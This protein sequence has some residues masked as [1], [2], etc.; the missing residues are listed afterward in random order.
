MAYF[1]LTP[2]TQIVVTPNKSQYE[3]GETATLRIEYTVDGKELV[4]GG[5]W[6]CYA[7]VYVD[8]KKYTT[9]GDQK[10]NEWG[11]TETEVAVLLFSFKVQKAGTITVEVVPK[12]HSGL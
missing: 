4:F 7:D 10:F 3:L 6:T 1:R 12:A 2:G 8:G 11:T 9:D 5:F